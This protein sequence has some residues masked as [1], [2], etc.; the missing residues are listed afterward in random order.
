[1]KTFLPLSLFLL[2]TTALQA[3]DI[4]TAQKRGES[5]ALARSLV[6][7]KLAPAPSSD[8]IARFNPF[9][10]YVAPV[11][12]VETQQEEPTPVQV[13]NHQQL[14]SMAG[15]INPTGTVQIGGASIL[16]IGQKKFKVGD[17]IPIN[18]EG[19]TYDVEIK[20]IERTSFTVRLK[21][22]E[23]TRPIKSAPTK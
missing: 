14:V 7:P 11:V 21:D 22:E 12:V 4:P 17:T 13:N 8:Q 20:S 19:A 15:M 18:F 23:F 5:L 6:D 2:T 3:V 9:S 16:L 1:M 10:P